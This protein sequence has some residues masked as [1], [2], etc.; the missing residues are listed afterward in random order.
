MDSPCQECKNCL[1]ELVTHDQ[2]VGNVYEEYCNESVP[3]G[4]FMGT[5]GCY[6]YEKRE[7]I[8]E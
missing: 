8:D 5:W 1:C 3:Y 4:V 2:W 6:L 7:D